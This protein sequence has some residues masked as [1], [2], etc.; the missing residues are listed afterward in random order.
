MLS[1]KKISGL[2][3]ILFGIKLLYK[4]KLKICEIEDDKVVIS[5]SIFNQDHY[6]IRYENVSDY[7]RRVRFID[8]LIGT[9][10]IKIRINGTDKSGGEFKYIPRDK[11]SEIQNKIYK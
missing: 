7:Q 8:Y 9:E 3:I 1:R 5:D 6:L 2:I 4:S 10:T 11:A